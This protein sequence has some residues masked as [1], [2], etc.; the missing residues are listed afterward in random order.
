LDVA[1]RYRL[2]GAVL[3]SLANPTP[4]S[5]TAAAAFGAFQAQ[6]PQN[7]WFAAV[8]TV[9][10]NLRQIRRDA[11]AAYLLG[12]PPV[13]APPRPLFL[14]TDDIY[15]Y[16]LIDPEMCSCALTTRLLQPSLAIQQFVQQAFL[17]LNI[18]AQ[19]D[20]T[21]SLWSEWSW[22]QQFRLW[23]A[24]R[25]VFL[26]PENYLLPELRTNA[27]SF[28]TDLENDLRQTNC[29]ANAAE[30]AF[31]NYM[32]KLVSVSRLKVAAH[33]NQTNAGPNR[34]DT[35]LHVFARTHG[36][37]AQWYYRTRTT[38]PPVDGQVIHGI[39]TPWT[40]L[41]LDITADHLLP[42]LWD[43]RLHLL[44]P[45]FKKISEQLGSQTIPANAGTVRTS[46]PPPQ[47]FWAIEFAM[48]ELSAGQWQAKKT[49]TNKFYLPDFCPANSSNNSKGG[50]TTSGSGSGKGAGT[51]G[52]SVIGSGPTSP[53]QTGG[54]PVRST[55]EIRRTESQPFSLP[56][57]GFTFT[58]K[59]DDNFQL[60]IGVYLQASYNGLEENNDVDYTNDLHY[61][62][63]SN[64]PTLAAGGT[65][66]AP[67]SP[68]IVFESLDYYPWT[69]IDFSQEPSF[70]LVVNSYDGFNV[71]A[72]SYW[73]NLNNI[74]IVNT[75]N[76]L[77][78][79]TF[80]YS[81]QDL[82]SG[83]YL[84]P[85]P[86]SVA[87]N[88]QS[89]NASNSSV[90]QPIGLLG[91]IFN[92]RI[93][94][95]QNEDT[96]DS[97][98]PFFVD[99]STRVYLV[100]P[101]YFSTL[102]SSQQIDIV[103][104][105]T[106]PSQVM[107]WATKYQFETFYHPFARTFVRE[108]EIGGIPKLMSR[109]LQTDPQSVRNWGSNLDFNFYNIYTPNHLYV[110]QPFPGVSTRP[111]DPGETYLD[112]DSACGGAY[113]E[114]NWEI[115]Y[116]AP[117]FVAGLLL[118]NQQYQDALT[119][120]EYIFNPTDNSGGPAPQRF[121]QM[122][123]LNATSPDWSDEAIQNLMTN[124]AA[125]QQQGGSN[126]S[127]SQTA[128][129][130]IASAN[131]I[132]AWQQDPYD[133]DLIARTRIATYA[134]ATVM[135]FLDTL[136][137]WGDSLYAQ[138]TA[139]MV[140]QA[141]QL[142]IMADM[143]LGPKPDQVRLPSQPG[144]AQTYA[145][146]QNIDP[147]SNVLL[148]I[149]NLVIA[150]E[151]PQ[152]LVQGTAETVT[153]PQ[154]P[155]T[156][157][158][159]YSLLFCIPPNQQLLAYWNQVA[160]RIYNIRHC[161]NLQGVAQPL[162]LYAPPI[163]PMALVAAQAS[164][165]GATGGMASAPIYRFAT[166]LQKAVELVNDVRSYGST[167]LAALEK[168]DAEALAVLHAN[169]ELDIQ[170]RMLDVKTQQV[171]EAQDQIT[172]LQNQLA[173]TQI[174]Y[175]FYSSIEPYSPWEITALSLQGAA[176]ISNGIAVISEFFASGAAIT[177]KYTLGVSG[178]GG[179]PAATA[180]F[181]GENIANSS[182]KFASATRGLAGILSESG[183]IAGSMG[184]YQRRND[185]WTLQKNLA[186]AE[187][188]QISSQITAATDRWNIAKSELD[189][190]T[191]QVNN[192]QTVSDFLTNK[193]T[194]VQLY[195]WM[196]SQLTT[197]Y[198]QAYQ[199]TFGMALQAQAAY[200]Y[201][202]GRPTD[203]FISFAYW[204]SQQKGLTAGDS[205]L[206]DL[207]RMEAQYLANN[208]RELEL[209]KHI[210]L[211]LTQPLALVTL[212]QS[213]SCSI[214]LDESVFDADHPG[215]YFRRLRSVAVTIPCVT[216][217]YTGVNATLTLGGTIVRTA[218][219]AAGFQPWQWANASS[220]T[221]AGVSSV[222]YQ[223]GAQTIATSSGQ[224]DAGLFEAN[225]RDERWLPFEGQGAVSQ[226]LLTLDPRDNNFDLST[227][228]DVIMHI[229]YTA[230]TGGDA[231]AVRK[232][233]IPQ[234]PRQVLISVRHTFCNQYYAFFNPNS[235]ATAQNLVLPLT[236]NVLPYANLGKPS[237]TDLSVYL[238]FNQSEVP[239]GGGI[240]QSPPPASFGLSITA[241]SPSNIFVSMSAN[242]TTQIG[243]LWADAGLSSA[244]APSSFTLSIPYDSGNPV[245]S[246]NLIDDIVLLVSYDF[247]GNA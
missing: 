191:A 202:L 188:T 223:A 228:T 225:L 80:G 144:M 28:F 77:Q 211:A 246:E 81:G 79:S 78:P 240:M 180:T 89:Q 214:N 18:A 126:S 31:E 6:Y 182:S 119:W 93:V 130:Y 241:S 145:S 85:N 46:S 112:F 142:Y 198:T 243:V 187:L 83:S 55:K 11:L 34:N 108:L 30:A 91:S 166:Y 141:E 222:P 140:S 45:N 224:N 184:S 131:A 177:P 233:L 127:N 109:N 23:Q 135:K 154:F 208:L 111:F 176:M 106:I 134:K 139:E 190:Q 25:E 12:N 115:F 162:P 153:L 88:V 19:I 54:G 63:P 151:P 121:W 149:E 1:A 113:S 58:A 68:L 96:F 150:P 200:Q 87:L 122:A 57:L 67:D 107:Q 97:L 195:N 47:T 35:V 33:Y 26:Y 20:T 110:Q 4:T 61:F 157:T 75:V 160:Q 39:W 247:G 22:R 174:R 237:I 220:N 8:Q 172:A 245:L 92:P 101:I 117:M 192:A 118:Q 124:L 226:W 232:A 53:P 125:Y 7:S 62:T 235:G 94:I 76:L 24:N 206:F 244:V 137:A 99:D 29:D 178:M 207:R 60:Q 21:N 167:I 90:L 193:F 32:R 199:I 74:D 171:T 82:V 217:P 13:S 215:Q 73:A 183:Q 86:G 165:A 148:P 186:N 146:L 230:R 181:G 116:H 185:E 170:T 229:R 56:P 72:K 98:D 219:P 105:T 168:Q 132:L 163:N 43:Q 48:S 179:T 169:Q 129:S 17:N 49:I 204:N 40:Q 209:T 14:T 238:L 164:G 143:L 239:P 3:V 104:T 27:S 9:E 133:P 173:V 159:V 203:Q 158:D 196:T 52:G 120:L 236:A 128:T 36:S 221:D 38:Q 234:G 189:I 227:V 138:Y 147:F 44:W 213:G 84:T 197:V 64:V 71:I 123:P 2:G 42:V 16:Y 50:G 218:P 156:G 194:S 216:G 41:N 161:L 102:N 103:A 10:D 242:Q 66:V 212:L 210:S 15:N 114:Y 95:P 5:D 152:N 37:P 231:E 205:L 136:L 155:G 59:Q 65:L 100:D 175:N 69:P 201:E 70:A 51:T